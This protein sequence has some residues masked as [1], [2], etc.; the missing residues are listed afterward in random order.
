MT[1]TFGEKLQKLRAREGMSQDRLAELLDV[2]RQAV[3]RWERDETMPE[4]EKVVR[5]SDCFHVTIDYLLKDGPEQFSP[6]R[7]V[8]DLEGWYQKKGYQLGWL[9]VAFGLYYIL[10]LALGS[11]TLRSF[12]GGRVMVWY[13]AC[14]MFPALEVVA[15]GLLTV[16]L[17]RRLAGHLHWYH[18]GWIGILIGVGGLI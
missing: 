9:A 10:R 1:L 18:L 5:I 13:L 16:M 14:Y 8:P 2:S 11:I 4:T 17:G 15:G 3:S 12:G 6:S 7:R